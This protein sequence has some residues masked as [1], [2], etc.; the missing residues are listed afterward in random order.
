M[1]KS[2]AQVILSW[3]LQ[4]GVSVVP[5]TVHEDRMVENRALFHLADEDMT[6]INKIV[7]S[8]GAARYLDP[9]GHIG[10]DIFSESVDE[11]VVAAE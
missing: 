3:A 6:K 8:T 11:P 1:G 5:K 2:P 10:F 7:K 9:K 4:R